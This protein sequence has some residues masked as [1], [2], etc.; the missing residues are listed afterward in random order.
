MNSNALGQKKK[1][2]W[3]PYMDSSISLALRLWDSRWGV[4]QHVGDGSVAGWAGA[5]GGPPRGEDV[6]FSITVVWPDKEQGR[7]PLAAWPP[8]WEYPPAWSSCWHQGGL[9]GSRGCTGGLE[10]RDHQSHE[11]PLAQPSSGGAAQPAAWF[12]LAPLQAGWPVQR[13][14]QAQVVFFLPQGPQNSRGIS[15]QGLKTSS[16]GS[17]CRMLVLSRGPGIFIFINPPG[18]GSPNSRI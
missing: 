1:D 10:G 4:G 15:G 12:L 6:G 9:G 8:P 11:Y 17:P 2:K 5:L 3:N 18:Q 7:V 16:L 14:L 13:E